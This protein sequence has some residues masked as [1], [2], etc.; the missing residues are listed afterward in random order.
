MVR[1]AFY[2]VFF[3]KDRSSTVGG[4]MEPTRNG[5]GFAT[6]ASDSSPAGWMRL[7]KPNLRDSWNDCLLQPETIVCN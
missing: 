5:I 2:Q 7:D 1:E 3:A 6:S 4:R